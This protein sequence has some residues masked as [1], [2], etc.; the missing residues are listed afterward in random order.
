MFPEPQLGPSG[1]EIGK[2]NPSQSPAFPA[3]GP[4]SRPRHPAA[5]GRFPGVREARG[6]VRG[7]SK[8]WLRAAPGDRAECHLS[9][10]SGI[11]LVSGPPAAFAFPATDTSGQLH[12]LLA[13]SGHFLLLKAFRPDLRSP[14]R[15]LF[16]ILG[17]NHLE[18]MKRGRPA[19]ELLG[20]SRTPPPSV[21]L[22]G[23]DPW[24]L[25][26]M[27]RCILGFDD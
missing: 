13:E 5:G 2:C 27:G 14:T 4:A 17:S 22:S 11:R 26:L 24:A 6:R 1:P 12:F 3:R 8:V 20:A 18:S 23:P 15:S 25:L 9:L 21:Q 7:S 19:Q 16:W 10:L